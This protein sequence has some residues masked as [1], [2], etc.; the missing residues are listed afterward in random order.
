MKKRWNVIVGVTVVVAAFC[1]AYIRHMP[2]RGNNAT[3]PLPHGD[4]NAKLAKTTKNESGTFESD[5]NFE[6]RFAQLI[7]F[8]E[9]HSIV[10]E[11]TAVI[12]KAGRYN[13]KKDFD[14]AAVQISALIKAINN[15]PD[16]SEIFKRQCEDLNMDDDGGFRRT[17]GFGFALPIER[18]FLCERMATKAAE[19]YKGGDFIGARDWLRGLIVLRLS[20]PVIRWSD[21]KQLTGRTLFRQIKEKFPAEFSEIES[22]VKKQYEAYERFDSNV[23]SFLKAADKLIKVKERPIDD[24]YF[25]RAVL[26]RLEKCWPPPHGHAESAFDVCRG[27]TMLVTILNDR[28]RSDLTDK[29]HAITEAWMAHTDDDNQ[30][31]WLREIYEFHGKPRARLYGYARMNPDGTIVPVD[32][33]GSE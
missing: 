12:D 27:I 1:A 25:D 10:S 18:D 4:D 30:K 2:K 13:R 3:V 14:A 20:Q 15:G 11:F 32:D 21:L 17:D 9:T 22:E 5:P 26:A 16:I 29:L 33:D 24:D 31:R 7:G 19:L 8:Q 6:N 28:K 23:V